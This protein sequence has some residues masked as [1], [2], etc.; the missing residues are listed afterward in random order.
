MSRLTNCPCCCPLGPEAPELHNKP[1][2]I[3]AVSPEYLTG[4]PSL[5][6]VY[7]NYNSVDVH[8]NVT[9]DNLAWYPDL[10]YV[11]KTNHN[12]LANS[13]SSDGFR[14]VSHAFAVPLVQ[15]PQY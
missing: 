6:D 5:D 10:G 13:A 9:I 1:P 7:A 15:C 14:V 12:R 4:D 2:R 11:V 8:L 3:A